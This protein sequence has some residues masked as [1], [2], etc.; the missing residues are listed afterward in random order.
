MIHNP[1]LRAGRLDMARG[2]VAKARQ[3]N[4]LWGLTPGERR[5]A[6]AVSLFLARLFRLQAAAY[7]RK[8]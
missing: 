4:R 6:V 7:E 3:M 2:A 5:E 1:T 8:I